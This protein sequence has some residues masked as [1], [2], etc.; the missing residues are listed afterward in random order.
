MKQLQSILRTILTALVTSTASGANYYVATNGT[1]SADG[2]LAT[3]FATIQAAANAMAPGDTCHIRGGTYHEQVVIDD[4]NGTSDSPITFK[5]YSNETVTLDGSES[6]DDLGSTGWIQHSGDIYKTTL[7]NDVWQLYVDDELMIPARWPNANFD[8]NSIWDS[9]KWAYGDKS[10]S[11]NGLMVDKPHQDIDLAATGLDMTG[12]MAVLNVGS[13]RTWTR[14]VNSHVAGSNSFT[15]SNATSYVSKEL[16][17]FLECKLNL[18]DTEK[19]W[20]FDTDTKTLY[21]WVEGGGTP[22]GNIRG[23]TQSYAFDV[24][25]SQHINLDGLDFFGTTFH[26]YRSRN[27]SARSC[28][29]LYPSTNKR[30]LLSSDAPATTFIEENSRTTPCHSEVVNCTFKYANSHALHMKGQSNRVVNCKFEYTD[31]S[32]SELPFTMSTVV[33]ESDDSVFSRNTSRTSGASAFLHVGNGAR[34]LF[35]YNEVSN[36]G[37]LQGDGAGFQVTRPCQPGSRLQYNWF[38]DNPQLGCRFDA[39]VPPRVWGSDG[40]MHHNVGWDCR[41]TLVIKGENHACYNNM[42]MGSKQNDIVIQQSDGFEGTITRNNAA[43]KISANL[44]QEDL[45]LPGTADHNWNGYSTGTDI[46]AQLRDPDIRDFRPK[47]GSALI[48]GGTNVTGITDGYQ[49]DAP[50]IGAYEYGDANYWIPGFQ[51]AK[52]SQPIP[53]NGA[54]NQ[55]IDRDLIWLG[56]YE[57]TSYDLYFGPTPTSL[58]FQ[59]NQSNNIFMPD[60]TAGNTNWYWRVDTITP[61]KTVTGPVWHYST[62]VTVASPDGYGAINPLAIEVTAPG[63]LGNDVSGNGSD[64]TALL[65]SGVSHGILEFNPDGSFVYAATNGYTGPDAFTYVAYDGNSFSATT[66]VSLVTSVPPPSDANLLSVTFG[67]SA[68][69]S[70]T[71]DGTSTKATTTQGA[72]IAAPAIAITALDIDGIGGNDDRIDIDF[73]VAASGG[74]LS[75]KASGYVIDSGDTLTFDIESASLTLGNG[76]TNYSITEVGFVSVEG[77]NGAVTYT[78][79]SPDPGFIPLTDATGAQSLNQDPGIGGLSQFTMASTDS[80]NN[81]ARNIIAEFHV[82]GETTQSFI[83]NFSDWA[84]TY[85]VAT[86][87]DYTLDYAFNINP[88]LSNH[89]TLPSSGNSGLPDWEL[90]EAEDRLSVEFV[91]RKQAIDLTYTAQ[92]TDSL[93]TNW[94][95]A[96]SSETITPIDAE[97]E[98]VSVADDVTVTTAS[99]RF[100]RVIVNRENAP[101]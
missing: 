96:V 75:R 99:N 98:R 42:G 39:P 41:G 12:A 76:A 3:P 4:L 59:T 60:Y 88:S 31:W 25:N 68:D 71:Y 17:Y 11:T 45:A 23:K 34:P 46:R 94:T 49:G 97:F 100:G 79:T 73:S 58:V 24:T 87:N 61:E 54:T 67:A 1:D 56:G 63:I 50:D 66:A 52:A 37:L 53:P 27:I 30:M 43:G 91:R 9:K 62:L 84:T 7:T 6:L 28:D 80:D 47:A 95:D 55:Q 69:R 93:T 26:F 2:S 10:T 78:V 74:A 81:R 18:L 38:H 72:D 8:D 29:L 5:N 89:Y 36:Y 86:N 16:H 64:L 48:D 51:Q 65:G 83:T 77:N 101:Q 14:Q 40:L 57:G 70:S 92:F 90:S 19:E 32:P 22:S 13:W 20:F 35:E 15:Y 33:L 44:I 21:L 85:N 82:T